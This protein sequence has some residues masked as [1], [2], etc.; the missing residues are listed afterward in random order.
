MVKYAIVRYTKEVV[1][2]VDGEEMA[3]AIAKQY[4]YNDYY[5]NNDKEDNIKSW[6]ELEP[7][8]VY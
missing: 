6:Y 7:E 5:F 4:A 2:Y 3:K 1:G 8:H